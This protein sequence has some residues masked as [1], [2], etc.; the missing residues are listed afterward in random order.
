MARIMS[1]DWIWPSSARC[2]LVGQT[3]AMK[4]GVFGLSGSEAAIGSEAWLASTKRLGCSVQFLAADCATGSCPVNLLSAALFS[5]VERKA[6]HLK[7][8]SRALLAAN[9]ALDS[10]PK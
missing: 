10:S 7:A 6:H 3:R 8:A 2:M 9:T 1:S 5:P 4:S